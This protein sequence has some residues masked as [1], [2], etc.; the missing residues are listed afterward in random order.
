MLTELFEK[1]NKVDVFWDAVYFDPRPRYW[2]KMK[3][4]MAAADC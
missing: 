1:N 2:L 4:K 3:Y